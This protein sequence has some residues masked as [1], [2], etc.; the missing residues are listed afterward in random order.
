MSPT[1]SVDDNAHVHAGDVIARIDD[2][3]YQL[4]VKTARDNIATQQATVDRIGK[5]VVAQEAAVDQAKAQLVSAQAGATRTELE[6]KRQR[7]LAARRLREPADARAGAGQSRPGRCR[8][9]VGT[10]RRSKRRK[11]MSTC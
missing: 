6:L 5:Q 8:R 10:R 9:A 2:G 11:P 1:S 3:D 7:D 4:A